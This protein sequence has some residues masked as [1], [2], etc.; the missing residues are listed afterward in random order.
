MLAVPSCMRA[1]G[2][3]LAAIERIRGRRCDISPGC[4]EGG[5]AEGGRDEV[6][7]RPDQT[8]A[9]GIAGNGRAS[10]QPNETRGEYYTSRTRRVGLVRARRMRRL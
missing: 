2:L 7:G 6:R 8:D 1:V 10:G 3:G 9:T 4:P 5:S